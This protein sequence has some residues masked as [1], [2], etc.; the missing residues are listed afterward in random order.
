MNKPEIKF[1]DK[2]NKATITYQTAEGT[3]SVEFQQKQTSEKSSYAHE[4]ITDYHINNQEV[5]TDLIA[6]V[7]VQKSGKVFKE[8]STAKQQVYSKFST[9]AIGYS[10]LNKEIGSLDFFQNM[11]KTEFTQGDA[12]TI[13]LINQAQKDIVAQIP[14]ELDRRRDAFYAQKTAETAK[15]LADKEKRAKRAEKI[16]K[17]TSNVMNIFKSSKRREK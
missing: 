5:K 13:K 7:S 4:G 15:L 10:D 9:D 17:I 6:K 3:V 12:K 14:Q 16:S 1:S 11:E 8:V 2:D